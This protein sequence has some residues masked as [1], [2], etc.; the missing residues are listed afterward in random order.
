[1]YRNTLDCIV[2]EAVRQ[3]GRFVLQYKLYCEVQEQEAGLP[4]SQGRQL[5]CD[6]ARAARRK[7]ARGAV[8]EHGKS[9][10]RSAGALG[11]RLGMLLGCRLCTWCTQPVFDLV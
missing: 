5:F 3:W 8:G 11:V 6:T 9:I 1:M 4:V 2:T 10:G 7:G